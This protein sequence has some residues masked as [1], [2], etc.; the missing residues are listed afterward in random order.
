M[1]TE[2][3]DLDPREVVA[4]PFLVPGAPDSDR[5]F[6]LEVVARLPEGAQIWLEAPAAL[7]SALRRRGQPL[8]VTPEQVTVACL[9]SGRRTFGPGIL[10]AGSR[11][12]VRILVYVPPAKLGL[13]GS[14]AVRQLYGPTEV[15]R[16]VFRV[17]P[18]GD[19][20]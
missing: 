2:R 4:V 11:T 7:M 20:P 14:V 12:P 8:R 6:S 10:P 13:G 15:G 1:S 9:P 16:I 3:R 17:R 5:A 19:R 18:S